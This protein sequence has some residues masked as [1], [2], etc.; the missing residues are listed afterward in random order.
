ME[1]RKATDLCDTGFLK[2][3]VFT[4][5]FPISGAVQLKNMRVN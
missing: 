2:N 3:S 5:E 4:N 1:R